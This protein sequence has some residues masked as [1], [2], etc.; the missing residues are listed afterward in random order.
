MRKVAKLPSLRNEDGSVNL[1]AAR[2]RCSCGVQA[3]FHPQFEHQTLYIFHEERTDQA[4]YYVKP[5]LR[6][7]PETPVQADLRKKGL[8]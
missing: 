7:R 3:Q 4:S 1:T 2:A 6:F 5:C 8:K